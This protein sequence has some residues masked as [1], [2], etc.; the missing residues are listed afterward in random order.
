[1][2]ARN[3]LYDENNNVMQHSVSFATF[4][5]TENRVLA[6]LVSGADVPVPLPI[7][8]CFYRSISHRVDDR[9]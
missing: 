2:D 4:S 3:H 7:Y 9:V 1:M 8:L 6:F 5:K